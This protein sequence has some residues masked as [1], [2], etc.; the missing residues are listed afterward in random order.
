MPPVEAVG[1]MISAI[2][3]AV[4]TAGAVIISDAAAAVA[5]RAPAAALLPEDANL[6]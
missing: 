6:F 5:Q 1:V 4:Q 2:L 3:R